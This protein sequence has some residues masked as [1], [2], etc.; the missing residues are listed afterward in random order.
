MSD[1]VRKHLTPS[2]DVNNLVEIR[3][4]DAII[5]YVAACSAQ[6]PRTPDK[7]LLKQLFRPEMGNYFHSRAISGLYMCLSGQIQIKYVDSKLK[8]RPSRAGCGPLLL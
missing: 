6:V 4:Y 2:G 3:T 5:G 8:N 1:A 7:N